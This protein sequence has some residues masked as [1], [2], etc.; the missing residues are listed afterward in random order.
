M[1]IK[2]LQGIIQMSVQFYL[3]ADS[4]L[5]GALDWRQIRRHFV[6]P[7]APVNWLPR[8]GLR[9]QHGTPLHRF[10]SRGLRVQRFPAQVIVCFILLLLKTTNMNFVEGLTHL[11]FVSSMASVLRI[12]R[13]KV[14]G[15]VQCLTGAVKWHCW[16]EMIRSKDRLVWF[17]Q[18][19]LR[20]SRFAKVKVVWAIFN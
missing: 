11:T 12:S 20:L 18:I 14:C 6:R 10:P 8:R 7:W 17:G 4:T 3:L 5:L 1:S 13:K 2:L 19:W 9:V 16:Q 15:S